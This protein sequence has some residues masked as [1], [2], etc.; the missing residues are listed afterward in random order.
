[1]TVAGT[2]AASAYE[3][4]VSLVAADPGVDAV[5][6]SFLE[7]LATSPAEVAAAVVR[8][9]G[10]A[11]PGLGLGP[12]LGVGL[13]VGLGV[14]LGVGLPVVAN[15]MA[16]DDAGPVFAAASPPI[17]VFAYPEAAAQALARVVGL[18]EWRRRPGPS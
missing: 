18:A 4:A 10:A 13:S 14:G 15:F 2:A 6:V 17:P 8:G 12:G 3:H 9:A 5:I 11:R 16:T 1:V 7:P